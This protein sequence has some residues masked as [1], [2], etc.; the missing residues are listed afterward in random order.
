MYAFIRR[1]GAGPEDAQ[2]LTQGFFERLLERG[3]FKSADQEKG[4]LRTFLRTAVKHYVV[5]DWRKRSAEK[6]GGG[7]VPLSLDAADARDQLGFFSGSVG[8][9][10]VSQYSLGGYSTLTMLTTETKL[11]QNMTGQMGFKAIRVWR[12]CVPARPE[13][14]SVI[15]VF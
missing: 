7:A 14:H 15:T 8:H 4:R 9:G 11:G 1:Q 6:R 13:A 2:D 10:E 12:H 5:Q 3:D